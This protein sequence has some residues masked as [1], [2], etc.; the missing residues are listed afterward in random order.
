VARLTPDL[1]DA[2]ILLLPSSGGGVGEVD[3]ER[4][5]ARG[6]GRRCGR[7]VGDRRRWDRP[8]DR[9]EELIGESAHCTEQLAVDVDLT[10]APGVV[11]DPHG[12]GPPP[13]RQVRQFPLGQVPLAADAEHDLQ[14]AGPLEGS[15]R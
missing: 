12:G 13:A 6:Q 11:A 7:V 1:P 4:S 3:E 2:A 8:L 9:I 14:V 15:G 5:G 10:L